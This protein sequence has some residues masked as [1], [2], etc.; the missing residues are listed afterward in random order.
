MTDPIVTVTDLRLRRGDF[1]LHVPS[2]EVRPGEIVGVVGPNGAGK[3]TL[4][5]TLPGLLA[6]NS[7]SV[8]VLGMDPMKEPVAVRSRVGFAGMHIPVFDV[9]VGEL[10]GI[11]SGY[12]DRWDAAWAE[13][14]RARFGLDPKKRTSALSTGQAMRL[15]LLLAMAFRPALLVLDEPTTGLDLAGRQTLMELI[16]KSVEGSESAVVLS[17]HSLGDVERAS[18]RLLVLDDGRVLQH[19]RTDELVGDDRTLEEAITAWGAA[20]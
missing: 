19:G 16:L 5:E 6:P 13:A 1:E 17:S 3:T 4:L 12:Y 10:I 18:E 14:L 11:F 20:G 15:R 9:R 7:G 8:R 2:W